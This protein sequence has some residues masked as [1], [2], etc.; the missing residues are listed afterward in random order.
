MD[1]KKYYLVYRIY[2]DNPRSLENAAF[3]GWTDSKAVLK[4]FMHQRDKRKYSYDVIDDE[5]L[6]EIFSYRDLIDDNRIQ[7]I[8]LTSNKT[9]ELFTLFMTRGELRESEI[10]I[11]KLFK[12]RC[13]ISIINTDSEKLYQLTLAIVNLKDKYAEALDM[14]GYQPY[15]VEGLFDGVRESMSEDPSIEEYLDDVYKWQDDFSDIRKNP[16]RPLGMSAFLDT[17]KKIL[18]SLE[19]FIKVMKNDL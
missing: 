11:Q 8:K 7:F 15:E 17:C 9:G 5:E 6:M 2:N 14:I 18:Y 3:Y 1:D 4:A 19:S 12:E 13:S 16:N 10:K